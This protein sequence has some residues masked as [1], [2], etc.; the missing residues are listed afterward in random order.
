MQLRRWAAALLVAV[1]GYAAVTVSQASATE[2]KRVTV[3][4]EIIDSWCY[5]SEIMWALGSAHHRCAIWCARGG[6]PVAILGEDEEVYVLLLVEDDPGVIGNEAVFRIQTNEV[7]VEGDLYERDSVKYLAVNK[8]V[9]DH[10]IVNY[11]H[12]EFDIQP[13]GL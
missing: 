6:V 8:I 12:E 3:T 2:S 1:V 5:L 10:G 7:V 11:S 4:G 13:G 9:E